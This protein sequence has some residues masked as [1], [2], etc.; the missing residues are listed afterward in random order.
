[1]SWSELKPNGLGPK[2]TSEWFYTAGRTV[3]TGPIASLVVSAW[4][5]AATPLQ[6]SSVAYQFG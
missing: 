2:K 1:M 4:T 6:S 3:M 5:W